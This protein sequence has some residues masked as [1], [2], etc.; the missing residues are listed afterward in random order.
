MLEAISGPVEQGVLFF[1]LM[2]AVFLG[3]IRLTRTHASIRAEIK[4]PLIITFILLAGLNVLYILGS[5]LPSSVERYYKALLYLMI[6]ILAIRIA[7][8]VAFHLWERSKPN[9]IP[10]LLKEIAK[11]IL[12]GIALIVIIQDTL[13]I[14]VTTVLA[15]SA[16]ITVVIGLALQ[17]TLGNLFA[18]LALQLDPAYQVGDWIR[19]GER[20]GKVEEITWRATKLRTVNND[21]IIIPNG[22]I[23]KETLMNLSYPATPHAARMMIRVS[24]S[25]PPNRVDRVIREVLDQT[26]NVAI[27]PPPDIRVSEFK[28]SSIDYDLKFYY[29]DAEFLEQMMAQVRKRLWY[30]FKRNGIEIPFP[31]RNIYIHDRVE[32]EDQHQALRTRLSQSLKQVY[33]FSQLSDAERKLIAD[34]LLEMRYANGEAIIREGEAGDSFFIIDHG[35]VEIFVTSPSGTRKTL[36]HLHDGDFFGEIALLTGEKRTA[37]V[38]AVSDVRVFQ[39]K[40]DNFK[41]VLE[42]KP[43]ILD[44]IGSV[45]SKRKDQLVTLLAESTMPGEAMGLNPEQAKHRILNRIRKYF[46]I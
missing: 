35:E 37:T 41:E 17:E 23:A 4:I 14:Q 27:N 33:L 22:S 40:K 26:P 44:E 46:G 19:V 15:T 5:Q 13:N 32:A 20:L 6:A 8:I 12:Y 3:A 1:I 45:L 9:K 42:R 2:A 39:L 34:N 10:R 29:I 28:E 31:I 36:T 18:G 16:V 21:S 11:A 38:Q 25:V 24:Y 30:H 43:D 7:I